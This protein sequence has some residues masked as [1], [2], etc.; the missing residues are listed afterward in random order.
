M[1]DRRPLR[2]LPAA[3]STVDNSGGIWMLDSGNF[4]TAPV[5]SPNP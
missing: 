5:D 3:L 2:L 1:H 4:N